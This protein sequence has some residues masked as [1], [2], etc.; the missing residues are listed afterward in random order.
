MAIVDYPAQLRAMISQGQTRQATPS[1]VQSD[2]AGGT[3]YIQSVT[4]DT[5]VMYD[6]NLRFESF[7]ASIFWSWFNNAAY[8]NKGRNQFRMPVFVDGGYFI[9]Q[10]CQFTPDGIPRLTSIDGDARTY[11]CSVIIRDFD[12]GPDMM[13]FYEIYGL[14]KSTLSIVDMA[15]N[16]YS[17]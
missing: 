11:S 13:E 1:F 6:F 7:H 17:T 9:Y 3:P 12:A 16:Q 10:V 14:D 5:P 4:D 15:I 8:C 2:P